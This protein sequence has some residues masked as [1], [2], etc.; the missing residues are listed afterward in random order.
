MKI[1]PNYF[2]PKIVIPALSRKVMKL[3][4]QGLHHLPGQARNDNFGAVYVIQ[5]Q[6]D[7]K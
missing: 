7:R 6:K 1:T 2:T 5:Q 4:C 3:E